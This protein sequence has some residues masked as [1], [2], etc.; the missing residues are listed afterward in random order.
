MDTAAVVWIDT[1]GRFKIESGNPRQVSAMARMTN[2]C[3][4][5]AVIISRQEILD[6][7]FKNNAQLE[8]DDFP[9]GKPL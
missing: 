2:E 9:E 7:E 8:D 1:D 6:G 5:P 3:G 4:L